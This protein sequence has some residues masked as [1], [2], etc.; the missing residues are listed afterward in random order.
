[1]AAELAPNCTGILIGGRAAELETSG[2][3]GND[4]G[5]GSVEHD[6]VLLLLG[7]SADSLVKIL[8]TA[9]CSLSLGSARPAA[10]MPGQ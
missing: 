6:V 9:P 4:D 2:V 3:L 10:A 1:M 5:A 8:A 7:Q